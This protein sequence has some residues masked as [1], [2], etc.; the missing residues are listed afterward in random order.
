V[1][2]TLKYE[3]P[4]GLLRLL[5]DR[6]GDDVM[7]GFDGFQWHTHADLLTPAYGP[8]EE[9]AVANF[10]RDI[11]EDRIV[12]AV[13]RVAGEVREVWVSDDPADEW[14][15]VPADQALELRY[16]HGAAWSAP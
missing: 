1:A 5:V 7:V 15:Y 4:D 12:V 13:A 14:K 10:V 2:I 9:E 16:W 3:S 11:L 6:E 8:T